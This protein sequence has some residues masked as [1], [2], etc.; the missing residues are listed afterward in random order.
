MAEVPVAFPNDEA[1]A[2]G[3]AA[4]LRSAG[5]A[6][7]IDR[8]LHGSWQVPAQGQMTV[9]VNARD[10]ARAHK[11]LGTT[12][13]EEGAPGPFLRLAVAFLIGA[14]VLGFVA[15]VVTLVSR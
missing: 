15:I 14:A 10:S 6:A 11:L 1:S 4:G 9:F 7:R 2:E 3:I 13:R 5:I 12:R 8:G